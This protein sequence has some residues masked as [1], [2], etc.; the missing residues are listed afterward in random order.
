MTTGPETEKTEPNLLSRS[1]SAGGVR[2]KLSAQLGL[3]CCRGPVWPSCRGMLKRG[4]RE[5]GGKGRERGDCAGTDPGCGSTFWRCPLRLPVVR[6]QSVSA[7]MLGGP[8][9]VRSER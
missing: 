4:G 5:Q 8:S 7:A 2:V 9:G 1:S 3:F 6:Q